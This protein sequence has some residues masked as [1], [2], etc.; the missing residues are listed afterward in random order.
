MF[1]L[2]RKQQLVV[3]VLAGVI[4]FGGGYRYAQ[5]KEK[6]AAE[7]RPALESPRENRVKEFKVHV[8][9]AVARPGV[10]QIPEGSRVIDAVNMAGPAEDAALDTLKLASPVIDGQTITVPSKSDAGPGAALGVVLNKGR[11]GTAETLPAGGLVNINTA[12]VS[13]LDTLPGIGPALAQR[14]IQYREANGPFRTPEDLKNVS[15]IGD[16]N[17]ERLKDSITVY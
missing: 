8:A 5:I 7:S 15:G 11:P 3:L 4:L 2:E 10:Y 16:K 1:R 14:I 12:D 6:A 9:G 13:Q 17:Y